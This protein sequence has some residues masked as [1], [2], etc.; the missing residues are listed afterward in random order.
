MR[1][2]DTLNL[3]LDTDLSDLDEDLLRIR[4]KGLANLKTFFMEYVAGQGVA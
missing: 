2:G 3:D 1:R 4:D